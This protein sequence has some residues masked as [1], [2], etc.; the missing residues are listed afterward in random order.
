MAT[1]AES[2]LADLD[3]LD[4]ESGAEEELEDQVKAEDEADP[5]A[6]DDVEALNYEDLSSVAHLASSDRYQSIMQKV[7]QALE[8]DELGSDKAW[9][10]VSETDPTYRLL[11]D[12][13]QLGVDIDNEIAIVHSFMKDKYRTKFPELESLVHHPID[14]ARV[15]KA[16]G[17]E[18]DITLVNLEDVL[19]QATIMV[20]SVTASTTSGKPL[21]AA[22]LARALEGAEASLQLDADKAAILKLV[23]LRMHQVAPNLSM[24]I[25]TEVAAKLMGVAGGLDALSR[26]P[27]CNIQ[28]LGA[29]RKT[30]AGFSSSS[31]QPHQG[32]ITGCD[33]VGQT[34]PG[35]KA[36]ALRLIGAKAALLAR[37][38]AFGQDPSGQ[39]G[40][41]FK[42]EMGKKIEK[43]QEPAPAKQTKVL[44]AP[45]MEPKKR[46]GGRRFR[47]MKERYG[48]TDVRKAANR[49]NFNQAEEEFL[50]GDEAIGLGTLGARGEG[51]RLRVAARN[52]K[53]KLTAATAKKYAKQGI[54]T[55]TNPL[56]RG[57]VSGLSS[58][59]A[60]T[61]VQGIEL[62]NPNARQDTDQRAGTESY[63]S[64]YSGF[65]SLKQAPGA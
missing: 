65:R 11:V 14:Y 10:G 47:K 57:P 8:G 62:E 46:R 15:I 56:G 35:L 60:F 16:I 21:S 24:A 30:L 25:G 1:L 36:K 39:T 51:G 27:A 37:V 59:L 13:N 28:V 4:N 12:C 54:G 45:D 53:Q 43:W 23:Q 40:S 2:F 6:I 5:M 38:D 18:M 64:E 52:Q 58:T 41:S 61:P 7:R 42:E 31:V 44:P 19:P 17:N 22:D 20:V 34:P 49:V 63:F 26:M 29:K 3:D 32:F 55:M 33:L 48:L 9:T 50:D